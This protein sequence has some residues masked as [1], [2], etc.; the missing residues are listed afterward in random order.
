MVPAWWTCHSTSAGW[1]FVIESGAS[2]SVKCQAPRKA[3]WQ[4]SW[5]AGGAH[6]G[7]L[8]GRAWTARP[9]AQT[10]LDPLGGL[11]S[12]EWEGESRPQGGGNAGAGGVLDAWGSSQ[13]KK[14]RGRGHRG[15]SVRFLDWRG[16]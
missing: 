11:D 9:R 3:L 6:S 14:T 5:G 10:C 13:L 15:S 16:F 8:A 12:Y 1:T 4:A 7:G 2:A